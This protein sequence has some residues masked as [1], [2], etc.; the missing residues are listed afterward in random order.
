MPRSDEPLWSE[1]AA[2]LA[3]DGQVDLAK[4]AAAVDERQRRRF[5]A[6]QA[7]LHKKQAQAGPLRTRATVHI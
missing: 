7:A 1:L 4:E 2:V 6:R 5:V 3:A